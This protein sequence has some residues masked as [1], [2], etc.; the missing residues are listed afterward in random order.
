[1]VGLF[2]S[3]CKIQ[4][5]FHLLLCDIFWTERQVLLLP[6]YMLLMG[7]DDLPVIMPQS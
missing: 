6:N 5:P 7:T 1:M 2:D 3:K 4:N